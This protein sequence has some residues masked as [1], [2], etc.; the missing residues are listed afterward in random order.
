M[1][2]TVCASITLSKP[3]IPECPAI[4]ALFAC[5]RNRIFLTSLRRQIDV[6]VWAVG[7]G[8]PGIGGWRADGLVCARWLG[9]AIT[10]GLVAITKGLAG[11][12]VVGQSR[13]GRPARSPRS[14]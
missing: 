12:R 7:H 9:L 10:K 13:V 6:M 8:S 14:S 4:R 3:T 11:V 2:E 1:P 5:R